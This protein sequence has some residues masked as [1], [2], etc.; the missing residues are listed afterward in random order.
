[1]AIYH[2]LLVI[3]RIRASVMKKGACYRTWFL[4]R[5]AGS[6][7]RLFPGFHRGKGLPPSIFRAA[8]C[9]AI[10]MATCAAAFSQSQ[11]GWWTNPATRILDPNVQDTIA[12]HYSP[13]NA[14]QLKNM[15]LNA[16]EHLDDKL[17]DGAG[18]QVRTLVN[19]F[20]AEGELDYAPINLGQLMAVAKPFYDRLVSAGYDSKAN[21]INRGYPSNWTFNYPWNPNT[22]VEQNYQAANVGQLMMVFSFALDG[23]APASLDDSDEDGIP[24]W[25]EGH[26]FGG[27]GETAAGDYDSD[28][29]SNISE[30]VAYADPMADE[31]NG[32]GQRC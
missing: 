31:A 30:L 3:G 5:D 11:P 8:A 25:L 2:W 13:A 20:A 12:S 26:V 21:L 15:A 9:V 6:R 17:P 32:V 16:M 19:G 1:M 14:G 27:S 10:I 22:P 29:I 28:A 4:W 7:V 23:F 24:D 18:S